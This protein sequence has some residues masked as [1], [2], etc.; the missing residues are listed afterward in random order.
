MPTSPPRSS[1]V[2][3][4]E[5]SGAVGAVFAADGR[6]VS[7]FPRTSPGARMALQ[8]FTNPEGTAWQVS[9]EAELLLLPHGTKLVP[10]S[11][12]K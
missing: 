4:D 8:E 2:S 10:K 12:R 1:P 9:S 5:G 11:E 6:C 7:L 3:T